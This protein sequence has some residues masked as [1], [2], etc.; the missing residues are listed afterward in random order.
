MG[1]D[2]VVEITWWRATPRSDLK[3]RGCLAKETGLRSKQGVSPQ[4]SSFGTE[5]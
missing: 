2:A 4:V 5:E 1:S 3:S